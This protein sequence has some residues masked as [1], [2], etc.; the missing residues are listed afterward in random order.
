MHLGNNLQ[1]E[2]TNR[3]G[4]GAH[5]NLLSQRPQSSLQPPAAPGTQGKLLK[6][7]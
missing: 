5:G 1:L 4:S 6:L 3:K 2:C 7:M